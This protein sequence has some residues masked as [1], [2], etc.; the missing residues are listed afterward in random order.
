MITKDWVRFEKWVT[1]AM[2]AFPLII[3]VLGSMPATGRWAGSFASAIMLI[4]AAGHIFLLTALL[5]GG[6]ARQWWH[7]PLAG[8]V[9]G[10][11]Q[12]VVIIHSNRGFWREAG[13]HINPDHIYLFQIQAGLWLA[14]V[15]R[16][17]RI[18][19]DAV[20]N[21]GK[22]EHIKAG[23]NEERVIL[24]GISQGREA[25]RRKF[26]TNS[27]MSDET[28]AAIYKKVPKEDVKSPSLTDGQ[29]KG[30][31]RAALLETVGQTRERRK[32]L[33]NTGDEFYE[34][35]VDNL[36]GRFCMMANEYAAIPDSLELVEKWQTLQNLILKSLSNETYP[37]HPAIIHAHKVW[38][39][40]LESL[41]DLANQPKFAY[42]LGA[43]EV[44]SHEFLMQIC[45]RGGVTVNLPLQD[46]W[47]SLL[48]SIQHDSVEGNIKVT[49]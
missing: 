1:T 26:G 45:V 46:A 48:K 43:L 36:V 3:L 28:M 10:I 38:R 42:M 37:D 12:A 29:L 35:T 49:R 24:D 9:A 25:F 2:V 21:K 41:H 22:Q 30:I 40:A 23:Q 15:G 16:Q 27:S 13:L 7:V 32:G 44:A 14:Y 39:E 33:G 20:E 8:L 31:M 34:A 4:L 47:A 19:A 5:G 18:I 6:M 17:I 11:V